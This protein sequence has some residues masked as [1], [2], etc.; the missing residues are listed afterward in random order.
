MSTLNDQHIK[1]LNNLI[2]VTLDSAHG[3]REAAKDA[4]NPHFKSLFEK[5]SMERHQVTAELQ[6]EVRGLGGKPEDEGAVLASVHRVFLTLK[7]AVAG[8][9]QA[10]VDEVEAGEDYIK[11]KFEAA[12][13]HENLSAPVKVVVAKL[14][15]VIKAGHNQMRELK[16]DAHAGRD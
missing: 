11:A 16:H 5:R 9:D 12:L 1:V 2:E 8:S 3:Y 14:Y 15:T 13:Q 4:T 10:V 6:A 7:N